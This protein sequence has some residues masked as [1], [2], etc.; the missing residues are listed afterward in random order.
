MSKLPYS[1]DED[2]S[3]QDAALEQHSSPSCSSTAS[4]SRSTSRSSTST[5]S[6]GSSVG[7]DASTSLS[8][9]LPSQEAPGS[10]GTEKD[11]QK[12][13]FCCCLRRRRIKEELPM[14]SPPTA[15]S[16]SNPWVA[17]LSNSWIGAP[18]VFSEMRKSIPNGMQK[19]PSQPVF[20]TEDSIH[21]ELQID[22]LARQLT[23][24]S[25]PLRST[26]RAESAK[27][28]SGKGAGSPKIVGK[29]NVNSRRTPSTKTTSSTKSAPS[30]CAKRKSKLPLQKQTK[31]AEEEQLQPMR[32][33]QA[34]TTVEQERNQ[35]LRKSQS[36]QKSK[37]S[38][39][40]R[41]QSGQPMRKSQAKPKAKR[42]KSK[43]KPKPSD[44]SSTSSEDLGVSSEKIVASASSRRSLLEDLGVSS[45]SGGLSLSVSVSIGFSD[46]YRLRD[47]LGEGSF[48][49]VFKAQS[50]LR[51]TAPIRAV[52][53]IVKEK[54]KPT[55]M[56]EAEML[57]LCDHPNIIRLVE[58]FEDPS[59]LYLIFELC[60]GGELFDRVI[61]LGSFSEVQAATCMQAMVRAIHYLHENWIAHRDVKPENFMFTTKDA[62][63]RSQLKLIDFG[64]STKFKEGEKLTTK[65]GTPFY[66]A[67]EVL[68]GAYDHRVDLW[69]LGAIMFLLLSGS[70]PFRGE[71]HS[72]ILSRVE[73]G[74]FTFSP[75][76]IDERSWRGEVVA[77]DGFRDAL[78]FLTEEQLKLK[79]QALEQVQN[80]EVED[81]WADISDDAKDLIRCLLEKDVDKRYS[82][83]ETLRHTWI[84]N[85]APKARDESLHNSLAKLKS[86]F[87]KMKE[88]ALHIIAAQMDERSTEEMIN[89]FMGLDSN[90]DGMLTKKQMKEAIDNLHLVKPVDFDQLMREVGRGRST[91]VNYIDFVAAVVDKRKYMQEDAALAAFSIVDEDNDGV[92]GKPQLVELLGNGY[93][94]A[95]WDQEALD[96]SLS[97]VCAEPEDKKVDFDEFLEMLKKP[98]IKK[99][100]STAGKPWTTAGSADSAANA[101]ALACEAI[102]KAT[103]SSPTSSPKHEK[104]MRKT[105]PTTSRQH[106]SP[107]KK[108]DAKV[109]KRMTE[110]SE[111]EK[112]RTLPTEKGQKAAR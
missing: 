81:V 97:F 29:S 95:F 67:P 73:S 14:T 98:N 26:A 35:R 31:G 1:Q 55:F 46:L 70:Q 108:E 59:D 58:I 56:R 30:P 101:F 78:P 7:N 68:S 25:S 62:I 27:Q 66:V 12:R 110:T 96:E 11:V 83:E 36:S 88:A 99:P 10:R 15:S 52:K 105:A 87:S 24:E 53:K 75:E 13:N 23:P 44:D 34:K 103:P 86:T 82:A 48:G 4:T 41:S 40:S 49:T 21:A 51:G 111:K 90:G 63:E 107:M 5:E 106:A 74:H 109:K 8:L 79:W 32:K 22:K 16:P 42:A 43:A 28:S 89:I 33:V 38:Q 19:E 69:S 76:Q 92:I 61:E 54:Q 84:H 80:T 18:S 100:W 65:V 64:I 102:G 17:S 104:G 93:L 2:T 85:L 50:M 91:R 6:L 57:Q 77:F 94:N 9:G 45:A 112:K 60:E 72:A 3:S 47:K 20:A 39:S 37:S 71:N